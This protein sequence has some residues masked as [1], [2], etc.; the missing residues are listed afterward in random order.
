M[1]IFNTHKP[2]ALFKIL[3]IGAV[4][5]IVFCIEPISFALAEKRFSDN[6]REK[7]QTTYTTLHDLK[8]NK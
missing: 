1:I 4:Q 7:N 6:Q 8:T 3:K 5:C 2:F